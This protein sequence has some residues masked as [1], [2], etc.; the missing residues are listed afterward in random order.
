M[1][2]FNSMEIMALAIAGPADGA[3][4]HYQGQNSGRK[5][6]VSSK[7]SEAVWGDSHDL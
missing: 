2:V 7:A 6:V 3:Q 1:I 4:T 5:K